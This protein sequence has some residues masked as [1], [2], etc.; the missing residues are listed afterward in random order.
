MKR[1]GTVNEEIANAIIKDIVTDWEIIRN[2]VSIVD[3]KCTGALKKVKNS[4]FNDIYQ[5]INRV[6]T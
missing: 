5:I 3:E 1:S 4:Y 6:M 2:I